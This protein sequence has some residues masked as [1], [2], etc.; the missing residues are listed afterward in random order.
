MSC[1]LIKIN[2]SLMILIYKISDI[3]CNYYNKIKSLKMFKRIDSKNRIKID[4]D[5]IE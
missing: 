3:N 1:S 4:Q 2:N 5:M